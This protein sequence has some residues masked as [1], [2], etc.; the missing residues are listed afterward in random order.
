M[1]KLVRTISGVT[2]IAVMA[3]P[4]KCLSNVSIAPPIKQDLKIQGHPGND[5]DLVDKMFQR[6]IY[7]PTY[8]ATP[9]SYTP[10][11]PTVLRAI[12]CGFDASKQVKLRLK[13][14]SEMGHP[15]DKIELIV[16][17][18]T[19]LAYPLDYQYQFIK[20][21]YDALNG[22]V[23]VTLHEAKSLN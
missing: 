21:C 2:P 23:S 16:M 3:Q 13:V 11:S 20:E 8:K 12:K 7:C 6:C 18:G 14:L 10:E 1:R 15:T 5:N 4:M 22:E 17:G 19:F 9:Q